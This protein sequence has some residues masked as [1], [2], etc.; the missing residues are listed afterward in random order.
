MNKVKI[1]IIGVGNMGTGHVEAFKEIEGAQLVAIA[2]I[3]PERLEAVKEKAPK[4]TVYFNSSD[5]L[6]DSGLVDA[7]IIA[8]PHYFH[9]PI[10]VK[11]FS[12][13]LHVLTEKPAGV[14][15]K[16]VREMNEAAEKSG[17]L[18]AIMFQDRTLPRHIK[19]KE[20]ISSG[21]LGNI[22]RVTINV[23]DWYR[24][25]AYYDSGTWRATWSGEGGGVLINQCPHDL[26]IWQWSIGMLPTKV[27]AFVNNG[28]FHDI[29]VEDD[30]SAYFEYA[31]GATG[32]FVTSSGDYPG[33]SRFEVMGDLGK[34]VMENNTIKLD[35]FKE[36]ARTFSNT[37]P[38][39]W[40]GPGHETTLIEFDDS[41]PGHKAVVQDFVNAIS[42]GTPLFI[43]GHEGIKGLTISNAIHL[44]GW[45]DKTIEIPYDEELYLSE[46]NKRIE[47]S[48]K[49]TGTDKIANL[50]GSF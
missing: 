19:L 33:F 14:Y 39:F 16:Q 40:S 47:G 48:K 12:K 46:L 43:S 11:A 27:R 42:N 10:A 35:K 17:K 21:E 8:T 34:L 1:G 20:I 5:E 31:N 13:G 24:T 29:E 2:D 30:V 23:T 15:T 9:P 32:T 37:D 38:N 50:D 4:D 36:N 45:L 7:V 6:I 44:S 3:S 41:F 26:D 22:L 49:K 18:F 25:Q 28:R